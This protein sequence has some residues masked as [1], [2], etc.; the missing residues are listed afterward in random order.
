MEILSE[1]D[2]IAGT[3]RTVANFTESRVENLPACFLKRNVP[4]KMSEGFGTNNVVFL[5][6]KNFEHSV[7][8]DF[9]LRISFAEKVQNFSIKK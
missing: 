7:D 2:V 6:A 4:A 9:C 8:F 3:E 5:A 1:L